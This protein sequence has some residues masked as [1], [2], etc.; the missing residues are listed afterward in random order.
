MKKTILTYGLLTGAVIIGSMIWGIVASEGKSG[1]S[2]WFGYLIMLVAMTM[3][4]VGVKRYRDHEFGGV[5]GFG[6]AFAL[7]LGI[8]L[9]ASII[10]VLA[11]EA[12]LA[13]T[14]HAFIHNYANSIIKARQDAGISDEDLLALRA[15]MDDLKTQYAN[16][17]FR[18]PM[19]FAEIFPLGLLVSLVSAALLRLPKVFPARG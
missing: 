2:V 13:L 5:I 12:Y 9:M 4:F 15:K 1:V 8:A 3:I 17:L 6:R 16:P 11:W 14:D 19:T 10:Y 18:L 7:G